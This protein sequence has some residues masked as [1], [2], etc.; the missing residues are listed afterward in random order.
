M[1]NLGNRG[2]IT[3]I[4]V[5][6]YLL[7]QGSEGIPFPKVLS[8]KTPAAKYFFLFPLKKIKNVK[9]LV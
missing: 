8:E 1:Y 4:F 2:K 3:L 7:L 6:Q 9:P 5:S